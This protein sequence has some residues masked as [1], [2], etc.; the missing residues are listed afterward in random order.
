MT[1]HGMLVVAHA[2]LTSVGSERETDA[3]EQPA[4]A[5]TCGL[6]SALLLQERASSDALLALLT[7]R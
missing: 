6:F 2:S 3:I 1:A 5:L 4:P 7:T